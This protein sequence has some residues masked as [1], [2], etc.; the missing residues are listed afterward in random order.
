M[1]F[2][3]HRGVIIFVQKKDRYKQ[4]KFLMIYP[5]HNFL[6]VLCSIVHYLFQLNNLLGDIIPHSLFWEHGPA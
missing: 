1:V 2:G 5:F 3:E 6:K 4:V